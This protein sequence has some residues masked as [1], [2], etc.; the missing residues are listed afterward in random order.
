MTFL[1]QLHGGEPGEVVYAWNNGIQKAEART[2][3]ADFIC[4]S[5]LHFMCRCGY[6]LGHM[7]V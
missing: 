2:V 7:D 3:S 1:G 6:V 5:D 4:L